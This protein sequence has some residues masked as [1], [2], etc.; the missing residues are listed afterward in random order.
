[1]IG[2]QKYVDFKSLDWTS[3]LAEGGGDVGSPLLEAPR[4]SKDTR[5]SLWFY[6]SLLRISE[7]LHESQG[8]Q[9]QIR[10]G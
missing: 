8:V 7:L 2:G 6:F 5:P 1:M 9:E 4:R 10:S 3:Y